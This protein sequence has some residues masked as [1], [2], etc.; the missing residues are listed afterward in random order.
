MLLLPSGSSQSAGS[1]DYSAGSGISPT[2]RA[3]GLVHMPA[4]G[5][6]HL[7]SEE[8]DFLEL[9]YKTYCNPSCSEPQHASYSFLH[10]S[11]YSDNVDNMLQS[12]MIIYWSQDYSQSSS[13]DFN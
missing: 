10:L 1:I 2:R 8:I 9:I 12:V 7:N 6:V 4:G 3:S 13:L 11:D 5:H